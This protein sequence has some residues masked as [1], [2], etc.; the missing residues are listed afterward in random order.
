MNVTPYLATAIAALSLATAQAQLTVDFQGGLGLRN[1]VDSAGIPLGNGNE[2][3][4]GY[5]DTGFEL[6]ANAS[7]LGA[8][9]QAWN[10]LGSTPITTVF[11]EPGR[12]SGSAPVPEGTSDQTL[13]LWIFKTSGNTAPLTDYSNVTEFGLFGSTAASWTLPAT[14]P[15]LPE[16]L[17]LTSSQVDLFYHG[18]AIS[19]DPGSLQLAAVPEP[20]HFALATGLLLAGFGVYRRR[21]LAQ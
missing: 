4:I 14:P 19:G 6:A 9:D 3:R 13:V 20:A 1:V 10:Q 17:Q 12:F 15:I 11:S 2:V 7:D 21:M 16:T 18:G 5:F 8:L